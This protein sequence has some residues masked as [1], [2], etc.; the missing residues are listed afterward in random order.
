MLIKH[1][2]QIGSIVT[3]QYLLLGQVKLLL[4]V[5]SWDSSPRLRYISDEL[6]VGS[7]HSSDAPFVLQAIIHKYF[8]LYSQF[9]QKGTGGAL[10][11][12]Q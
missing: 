1:S 7:S 5:C 2:G 12:S 11:P 8:S 10:T 6:H 4:Q 3:E 9:W